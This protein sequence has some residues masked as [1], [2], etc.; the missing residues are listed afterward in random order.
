MKRAIAAVQN[1]DMGFWKASK[2]FS[3]PKTTLRR[4]AAIDNLPLE[5][6][7][8]ARLG[9]PPVLPPE[10]ETNANHCILQMESKYFGLTRRDIKTLAFQKR[11]RKQ[12]KIGLSFSLKVILNYSLSTPYRNIFR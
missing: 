2:T 11:I 8:A 10:I 4:L 9:R 5:E 1:G 6:I 7:V 3:V 12:E